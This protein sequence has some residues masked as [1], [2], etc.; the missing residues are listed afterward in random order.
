M[1]CEDG[2]VGGDQP[3]RAG[4]GRA[5]AEQPQQLRQERPYG[6]P[7]RDDEV[8]A[9]ASPG[10][11]GDPAQGGAPLPGGAHG[12][13][14][15]GASA[16]WRRHA[17]Q[18]SPVGFLGP[19]GGVCRVCRGRVVSAPGDRPPISRAIAPHPSPVRT[20]TPYGHLRAPCPP[21]A[22]T[23]PANGQVRAGTGAS[24]PAQ[25]QVGPRAGRAASPGTSGAAAP[26]EARPS[27]RG[28]GQPHPHP[29]RAP[30]GRAARRPGRLAV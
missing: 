1:R 3:L 11:E 24:T 29:T 12:R 27:L 15:A 16:R 13:A 14:H 17:Q 18:P 25:G 4:S 10:D 2:V 21:E 5:L 7:G 22:P 20:A 26:G 30:H 9:V 19:Y 6:F 28:W 8:G 23:E